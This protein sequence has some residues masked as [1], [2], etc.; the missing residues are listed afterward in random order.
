MDDHPGLD[1]RVTTSR[2]ADPTFLRGVDRKSGRAT[3]CRRIRVARL[4]DHMVV[5]AMAL[6]MGVNGDNNSSSNNNKATVAAAVTTLSPKIMAPTMHNT[7]RIS[8]NN[9][10][11][12]QL[13]D[14]SPFPYADLG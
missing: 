7:T 1:L 8:T 11:V 9:K 10:P 6:R 5:V 2:Q 12:P 13:I 4:K 3:S 14:L